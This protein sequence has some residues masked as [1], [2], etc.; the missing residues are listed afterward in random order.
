M[1]STEDD[2]EA[3]SEMQQKFKEGSQHVS[4]FFEKDGH[5]L[6]KTRA[7]FLSKAIKFLAKT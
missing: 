7:D 2:S 5:F 6:Q 4:I 1:C 3:L